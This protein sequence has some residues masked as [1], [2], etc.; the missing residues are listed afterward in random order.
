MSTCVLCRFEVVT[1]DVA[2]TG[3][4]GRCIC[5][6]CYLRETETAQPLSKAL[7]QEVES[8][9]AEIAGTAP[10]SGAPGA[11]PSGPYFV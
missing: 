10:A 8:C 7:R 1:D 9:L 2:L 4:Q 11:P 5:L 6:R 3:P